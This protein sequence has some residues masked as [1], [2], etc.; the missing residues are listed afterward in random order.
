MHGH[1]Y[2]KDVCLWLKNLP[3][4]MPT[5]IVEGRKKLDFWSTKRNPDGVSLKSKTFP[6]I[7]NAMASQWGELRGTKKSAFAKTPI[8]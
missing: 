7:A 3:A 2:R 1:P 5:N 4:I 8:G 6:G